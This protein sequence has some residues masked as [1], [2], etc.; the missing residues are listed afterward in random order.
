MVSFATLITPTLLNL[1]PKPSYKP[2]R[3]VTFD[4]ATPNERESACDHNRKWT[5]IGGPLDNVHDPPL[6]HYL[7]FESVQPCVSGRPREPVC[8]L[9]ERAASRLSF[10]VCFVV[11]PLLLVSVSGWSWR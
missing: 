6:P 2:L 7:A 10:Q 9:S 3:V 4:A 8:N 1:V 5:R 11:F